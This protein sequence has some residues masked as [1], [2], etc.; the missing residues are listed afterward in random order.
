M[1]EHM[2]V[3]QNLVP[4][5]NIKIAGKW[6]FMPTKNRINRYWSIP[7]WEPCRNGPW[8]S[9]NNF[10]CT[11]I[12]VLFKCYTYDSTETKISTLPQ[13]AQWNP[14]GDRTVAG[15]HQWCPRL[16]VALAGSLVDICW[17]FAALPTGM[18]DRTI[19]GCGRAPAMDLAWYISTSLGIEHNYNKRGWRWRE[20]E[21]EILTYDNVSPGF[22]NPRLFFFFFWG[23]GVPT[24]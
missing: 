9:M 18:A 11:H 14:T 10:E 20:G 2:A 7:I 15:I 13:P 3:C 17:R 1:R 12:Q 24:N 16:S 22:R 8:T 23:G 19:C 4:L 6:M 5:V 21:I